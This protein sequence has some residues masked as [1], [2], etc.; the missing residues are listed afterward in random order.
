MNHGL[1]Q[2]VLTGN[3]HFKALGKKTNASKISFTCRLEDSKSQQ[4]QFGGEHLY[5][6]GITQAYDAIKELCVD[7]RARTRLL[8]TYKQGLKKDWL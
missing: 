8:Q 6:K 5:I 4:S 7:I 3:N 2:S 1:I